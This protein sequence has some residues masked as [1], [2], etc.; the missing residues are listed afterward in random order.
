M[1]SKEILIYSFGL[2]LLCV[3]SISA[4][5]F[6]MSILT[7]DSCSPQSCL[8]GDFLYMTILSGLMMLNALIGIYY[9]YKYSFH[10]EQEK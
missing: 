3:A 6:F 1:K 4:L 10:K 8:E 2:F 9:V 7:P 5:V